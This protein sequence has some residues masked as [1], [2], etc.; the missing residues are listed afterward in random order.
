MIRK[1]R[2]ISHCSNIVYIAKPPSVVVNW[3]SNTIQQM[4]KHRRNLIPTPA[5]CLVIKRLQKRLYK[6]RQES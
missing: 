3:M 5:Q 4:K 2:F 1:C 6:E